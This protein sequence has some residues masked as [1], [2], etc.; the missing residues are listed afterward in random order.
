MHAHVQVIAA[1]TGAAVELG[2]SHKRMVSRAYHDTLFMSQVAPFP[3]HS[4]CNLARLV[5]VR[6]PLSCG[7]PE[8]LANACITASLPQLAC[9]CMYVYRLTDCRLTYACM[10]DC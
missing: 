2:A 1:A 10:H 3:A 6:P 9:A 5:I 8:C 4:A 7:G